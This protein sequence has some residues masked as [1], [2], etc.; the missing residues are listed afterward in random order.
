MVGIRD[1]NVEGHYCLPSNQLWATFNTEQNEK[2]KINF[3]WQLIGFQLLE[4]EF[5]VFKYEKLNDENQVE[6]NDMIKTRSG[7]PR[8]NT[9]V[10]IE[11][12]S[13]SLFLAF[14]KR[15]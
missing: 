1:Q 9:F 6:G 7:P 10:R 15:N 8:T 11:L 14:H 13:I 5:E 2:K 3:D 12:E 4:F